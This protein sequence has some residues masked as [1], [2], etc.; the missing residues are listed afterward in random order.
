MMRDVV[1]MVV[2]HVVRHMMAVVRMMMVMGGG[3][4]R[5]GEH[6]RDGNDDRQGRDNL[7]HWDTPGIT[8]S[9]RH[10]II[11]DSGKLLNSR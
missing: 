1:V 9:I 11:R 8:V 3:R 10:Y 4:G 2:M 6:Q 7:T 5:R